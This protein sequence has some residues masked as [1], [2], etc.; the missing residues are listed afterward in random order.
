M[1]NKKYLK[2]ILHGTSIAIKD[3]LKTYIKGQELDSSYYPT[4][5]KKVSYKE[6]VRFPLYLLPLSKNLHSPNLYKT[7][8]DRISTRLYSKRLLSLSRLSE[9]LYFSAGIKRVSSSKPIKRMYP[10][11]GG[12]YPLEIYLVLIKKVKGL[13]PGI[14]H[15][16][17]KRH[18]L[19]LLQD[20]ISTSMINECFTE[21]NKIITDSATGLLV[22]SGV[23]PRIEVKYLNRTYRFINQEVGHLA[24]NI[25]LTSIANKFKT[26]VI[27][28]FLDEKINTLLDL[29]EEKEQS[30]C[31]VAFGM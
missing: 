15:Y 11:A 28:G 3:H 14:Y 12:R 25:A 21:N 5:W 8:L 26:C 17:V 29:E 16:N 7:L 20:N 22:I 4:V 2:K 6:Y 30:L 18:G 19:E 27:G 10:S 24:Q 1:I 31:I 23:F 13:N 9:I